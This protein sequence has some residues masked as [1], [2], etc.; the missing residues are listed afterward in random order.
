MIREADLWKDSKGVQDISGTAWKMGVGP[1]G[2]L[3]IKLVKTEK[4]LQRR[5]VGERSKNLCENWQVTLETWGHGK[6]GARKKC[7]GETGNERLRNQ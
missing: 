1:T 4:I 7:L 3:R 6:E 5:D 2:C